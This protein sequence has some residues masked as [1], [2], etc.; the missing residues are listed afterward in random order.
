MASMTR[1]NAINLRTTGYIT[2]ILLLLFY[3]A[4]ILFSSLQNAKQEQV[5]L[6]AA[7][8]NVKSSWLWGVSVALTSNIGTRLK[9]RQ[10]L[11]ANIYEGTLDVGTSIGD[12]NGINKEIIRKNMSF[13]KDYLNILK[14]NVLDLLDTS[15]DRKATLE[16]FIAQLELRYKDAS[17]NL[18]E[19][20]TQLQNLQNDMT[21]VNEKIA[22]LKT[23]IDVDFKVFDATSTNENIEEYFSLRKQYTYDRTYI[24]FINQFVR[25]YNFLNEYNKK[26]LDTLINNKW[27]LSSSSFVVI[28]D[29]GWDLLK[30][31][32]LIYD[33]AEYKAQKT[34][35]IEE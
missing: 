26:L 12:G 10:S 23:K 28:P 32:N 18:K 2:C 14:T 19:L 24:I 31:L 9:E 13:V 5:D 25:Q 22:S 8:K 15:S 6:N 16:N 17:L 33:E 20:S 34:E 4:S 21:S 29:S 27:A 11:P 35:T 1:E 7:F 30:K 3:T